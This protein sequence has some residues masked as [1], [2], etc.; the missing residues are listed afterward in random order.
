M[1]RTTAIAALVLT[2]L[3]LA[4]CGVRGPLDPPPGGR[5]PDPEEPVLLDPLITPAPKPYS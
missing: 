3:S 1:R 4:G 5:E 2:A